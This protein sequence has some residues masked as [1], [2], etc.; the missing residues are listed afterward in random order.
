[1]EGKRT[2]TCSCTLLFD[3]G[4]GDGVCDNG[5]GTTAAAA[6]AS[7][8]GEKVASNNRIGGGTTWIRRIQGQSSSR[9]LLAAAGGTLDGWNSSES[10]TAGT[11]APPPRPDPR[12]GAHHRTRVRRGGEGALLKTRGTGRRRPSP[13]C[14]HA[15][16]PHRRRRP[17]RRPPRWRVPTASEHPRACEATLPPWPSRERGRE[18]RAREEME[19]AVR[20][21]RRQ[22]LGF[23]GSLLLLGLEAVLTVRSRWTARDARP[24][25][26]RH[27]ETICWC[28]LGPGP[29][30]RPV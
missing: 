21:R 6:W 4:R 23:N 5:V 25:L 19:A 28:F 15:R 3:C 11:A 12:R 27:D 7:S 14:A 22:E 13:M 18:G 2:S 1:M 30:A 29:A 16:P 24:K 17:A 9:R 10:S 8:A 26:G 20:E